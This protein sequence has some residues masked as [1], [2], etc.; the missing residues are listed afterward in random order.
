[1]K[2]IEV[3]SQ[4]EDRRPVQGEFEIGQ[5]LLFLDSRS[6][7]AASVVVSSLF[8]YNMKYTDNRCGKTLHD[9]LENYFRL[10]I[11]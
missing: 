1:M 4:V 8:L 9:I 10:E 2:K 6:L 11:K 5:E 3:F 7:G